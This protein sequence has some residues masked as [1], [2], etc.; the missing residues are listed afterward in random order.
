MAI[1]EQ[2]N[3]KENSFKRSVLIPPSGQGD[4]IS[5]LDVWLIL[6]G[7]RKLIFFIVIFVTLLSVSIALLLPRLYRSE[8]VVLPPFAKDAEQ[9]T[10]PD[11]YTITVE[12]LYGK[13][14][15]NLQSISL[16]KQFFETNNLYAALRSK[17][18]QGKDEYEVFHKK[19]HN[20]L[21]VQ[22][23]SAAN[24][25][26]NTFTVTLDGRDRKRIVNWLNDYVLLVDEYTV[27][28]IV[29]SVKA[30]A[31]VQA[32]AVGEKIDNLRQIAKQRRLD[33]IAVLKEAT[34][35]AGKLQLK[36]PVG[37][38][39]SYRQEIKDTKG[40]VINIKET[41]SYLR[42]THALEAEVEELKKRKNDDPFI[43]SLR[44]LQEEIFFYKGIALTGENLHAARIDQKAVSLERP[45]KPN[46]KLIVVL[47]SMIGVVVAFLVAFI[48]NG[49]L[50]V[51]KN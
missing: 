46:K 17:N 18:N 33:R 39:Y 29:D 37:I 45:V 10:V 51:S 25:K 43:T 38:I 34:A 27:Q 14:I 31:T 50:V 23:V 47:G 48:K 1:I 28:Q 42:G 40:N 49:S 13:F 3:K 26:N 19:F 21:N 16:Q 6:H 41:P 32:T 22:K 15:Q 24:N 30:K 20:L 36:N 11:F 7:Q 35:V 9:L 4:E 8:I 2:K 44:D 12:N 5:L